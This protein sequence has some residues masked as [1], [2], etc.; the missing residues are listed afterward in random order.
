MSLDYA[1]TQMPDFYLDG[2]TRSDL[3]RELRGNV[4]LCRMHCD[5]AET[6]GHGPTIRRTRDNLAYAYRRARAEHIKP[7]FHGGEK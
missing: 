5:A 3:E 1:L 4:Y 6:S 7:Y 2:I